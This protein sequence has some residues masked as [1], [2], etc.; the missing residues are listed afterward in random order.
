MGLQLHLIH[1]QIVEQE[2]E[3]DDVPKRIK[4][5][6]IY[7]IQ[8]LKHL[9]RLMRGKINAQNR[10]PEWQQDLERLYFQILALFF[11]KESLLF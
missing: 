3:T 6:L 10:H 2:P 1:N 4:A 5:H 9:Y 8:Y 7:N 11:V